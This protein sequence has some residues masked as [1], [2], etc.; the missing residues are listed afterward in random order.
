MVLAH[1]SAN[2]GHLCNSRHGFEFLIA[3]VPVLKRPQ[4]RQAFG[5]ASIQQRIFI[6]PAGACRIRT[7]RRMYVGPAIAPQSAAGTRS[8]VTAPDK[9]WFHPETQQNVG[10]AKH[11]LRSHAFHTS[12]AGARKPSQSGKLLDPEDHAGRLACPLRVNDHLHVADIRQCIQRHTLQAPYAA[13]ASRIAPSENEEQGCAHTMRWSVKSSHS[14][15]AL[16]FSCRVATT[17]PPR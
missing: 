12:G 8:R 2:A 16:P 7:N 14:S 9:G 1:E 15:V 5:M 17:S 4:I 6:N 13:T 3:Q 11:R 10:V